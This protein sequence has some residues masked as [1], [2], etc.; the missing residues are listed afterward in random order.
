MQTLV[1]SL[2]VAKHEDDEMWRTRVP[3][4]ILVQLLQKKHQ[5]LLVYWYYKRTQEKGQCFLHAL[6]ID[7]EKSQTIKVEMLVLLILAKILLPFYYRL[8]Q[9]LWLPVEH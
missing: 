3:Y 7:A 2:L 9:K 5:Q 8:H 4:P 6:W 1:Q